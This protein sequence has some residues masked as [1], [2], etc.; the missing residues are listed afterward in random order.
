MT[1]TITYTCPT[2][3][4]EYTVDSKYKEIVDRQLELG[5]CK[6]CHRKDPNVP[7]TAEMDGLLTPEDMRNRF[8]VMRQCFGCMKWTQ[9]DTRKEGKP[10]HNCGGT[11]FDD[12]FA[13]SVRTFNPMTDG[14]RK[15]KSR[16]K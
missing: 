13:K 8:K 9:Q 15:V 2:C 12:S 4:T 7:T 16:K 6:F 14:K 10:C 11:E 5:Y 3:G 1:D